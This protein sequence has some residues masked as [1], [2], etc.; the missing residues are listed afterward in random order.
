M[1]Q[2]GVLEVWAEGLKCFGAG[3]GPEAVAEADGKVVV[4]DWR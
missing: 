3:V 4:V 1:E 2:P